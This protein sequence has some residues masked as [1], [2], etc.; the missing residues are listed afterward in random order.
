MTRETKFRAFYRGRIYPVVALDWGFD[1]VLFSAYLAD[2][3]KSIKV[4]DDIAMLSLLQYTGLKDKNGVEIY[5][6]DI[7]RTRW[8]EVSPED[9]NKNENYES[10]SPCPNIMPDGFHYYSELED[11]E[12]KVIGNMHESPEFY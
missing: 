9:Y 8:K 3:G 5:E 1:G 7:I 11:M 6:G 4:Y 2:G 10:T 12:I